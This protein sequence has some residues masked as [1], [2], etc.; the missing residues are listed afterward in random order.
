MHKRSPTSSRA[1]ALVLILLFA[2]RAGLG[3]GPADVL[4]ERV[5]PDSGVT[6]AIEDLKGTTRSMLDSP[7][8]AELRRLPSVRDGMNSGKFVAFRSAIEA[9]EKGL[10][11]TVARLRD[12]LFGEALVLSLHVPAAKPIEAARGLLL[13]RVPDRALLDR[14]ILRLNEGQKAAG[15][16]IELSERTHA[17]VLYHVRTFRPGARDA[18]FY[19][20]LDE[21]TFAWSNSEELI[22]GVIDRGSEKGKGLAD[23]PEYRAV[24]DGLPDGAMVRVFV[25]P[26]FLVR[27]LTDPDRSRQP[28]DAQLRTLATRYLGALT[29]FGAALKW[30]D[31]LVL[32]TRG[33]LSPAALTPALKRWGERTDTPA[34]ELRRVPK[35]ALVLL[36]ASLDASWVY[37]TLLDLVPER[38]RPKLENLRV[39][40]DGILL[41]RSA[42]DEVIPRLGPGLV[43]YLERPAADSERPVRGMPVVVSVEVEKTRAGA[44][45]SEAIGNAL[46]TLLALHALDPKHG[47]GLLQFETRTLAIGEVSALRPTTPFAFSTGVGKLVLG[48]TADAVARAL[49]AQAQEAGPSRFETIRAALFPGAGSFACADLGAIHE[50]AVQARPALVRGLAHRQNAGEQAAGRDLDQALALIGLFDAAY[51]TST[52]EPGFH[53]INHAI[54]LV[55]LPRSQS[56]QP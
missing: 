10:G 5:P 2:S 32:Q 7:L 4:L 28:D 11:V 23:R 47:E 8:V 26:R 15:E 33:L 48:T 38:D 25:D 50:F 45:A 49:L 39:A 6:I 43:A 37:E 31:G 12:D 36:S 52:I 9:V 17:N 40:L 20:V 3:S 14:L 13:I 55:R 1:P 18:E 19:A 46:R 54:G 34:P 27:A 24:R 41:G 30:R 21:R 42:R 16:L 35:S 53:T 22:R 56:P 51:L 29:Y 44:Q